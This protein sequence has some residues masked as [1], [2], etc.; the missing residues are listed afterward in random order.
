MILNDEYK[1]DEMHRRGIRVSK[2]TASIT[3][4]VAL[5]II[6]VASILLAILESAKIIT[7]RKNITVYSNL[8][9]ESLFSEYQ[10]FLYDEY[11]IFALD[12]GEDTSNVKK[13]IEGRLDEYVS[14]EVK[15]NQKTL[16][17]VSPSKTAVNAYEMLTDNDGE[18]FVKLLRKVIGYEI[19][20]DALKKLK[21][22]YE[23]WNMDNPE[24]SSNEL[25]GESIAQAV[26]YINAAEA[27]EQESEASTEEEGDTDGDDADSDVSE[28]AKNGKND[29]NPETG[30]KQVKQMSYKMTG[31]ESIYEE[32]VSSD[33][34]STE[35]DDGAQGASNV[36]SFLKR[37]SSLDEAGLAALLIDNPESISNLSIPQEER[38]E[39][40]QL[41]VGNS[42]SKTESDWYDKMIID[43]FCNKHMKCY[44]DCSESDANESDE[45]AKALK[46]ELEYIV[47]SEY[48]DKENLENAMLYMFGIRE[49]VNSYHLLTSQEKNNEALVLAQAITLILASPEATQAVQTGIIA[50]WATAETIYEIR[51]LTN[52][53][54]VCITKNDNNWNLGLSEISN[55]FTKETNLTEDEKGITYKQYLAARFVGLETKKLSYRTMD[56]ME[57]N[58]RSAGY[59]GAKMD[60]M[61]IGLEC[62]FDYV[63]ENKFWGLIPSE[64]NTFEG[65]Y[66]NN[67]VSRKYY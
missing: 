22:E 37:L 48:S 67:S 47:F 62:E 64:M 18:G 15:G 53:K 29:G 28:T 34:Q 10:P 14:M 61:L 4:F 24:D 58:T 32:D 57:L 40:R 23:E 60:H 17:N 65:Y 50:A 21:D 19:T 16:V 52:G 46:Y 13:S 59:T 26:E 31:E 5:L 41:L 2:L 8:A 25:S 51:A 35:N 11:K 63:S 55:C 9:T 54:K 49:A 66:L 56:I 6:V 3:I 42:D 43:Y 38:L 20:R 44:T 7:A 45:A 1:V 12:V 30:S 36:V 33:E 27:A 39:T